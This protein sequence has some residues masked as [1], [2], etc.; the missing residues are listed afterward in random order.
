MNDFYHCLYLIV[1]IHAVSPQKLQKNI[2]FVWFKGYGGESFTVSLNSTG[3]EPSYQTILIAP[4]LS[5][6]WKFKF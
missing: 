6:V 2:L 3:L 4:S 1:Y 5:F